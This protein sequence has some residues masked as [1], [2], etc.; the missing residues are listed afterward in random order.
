MHWQ[1]GIPQNIYQKSRLLNHFYWSLIYLFYLFL[2]FATSDLS[3]IQ[4]SPSWVGILPVKSCVSCFILRSILF[5]KSSVFPPVFSGW[6]LSCLPLSVLDHCVFCPGSSHSVLVMSFL[7]Q[8][9]LGWFFFPSL[10]LCYLFFVP[11]STSIITPT[12]WVFVNS[13][14]ENLFPLQPQLSSSGSCLNVPPSH[15][16]P[17]VQSYRSTIKEKHIQFWMSLNFEIPHFQISDFFWGGFQIVSQSIH[18]T[19]AWF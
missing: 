4:C 12:S 11:A 13:S 6:C 1:P 18:F 17:E 16:H 2:L 15:Y 3:E 19:N 9:L 14:K 10:H 8:M 7:T 5:S